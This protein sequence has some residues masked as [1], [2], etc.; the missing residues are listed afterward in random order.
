MVTP[1]TLFCAKV[2]TETTAVNAASTTVVRARVTS[3]AVVVKFDL[4]VFKL[5]S[6]AVAVA[7]KLVSSAVAVAA[8]L[9]SIA[10]TTAVKLAVA[11]VL[12]AFAVS[13][14]V[15]SVAVPVVCVAV[16]PVVSV[17]V[18]VEVWSVLP[19]VSVAPVVAPFFPR[20]L[21]PVEDVDRV[22]DV[23]EAAVTDFEA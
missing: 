11:V 23:V 6:T 22:D 10:V 16:V 1:D 20:A 14:A 19:V 3:S 9:V 21:C 4:A 17:E 15:D 5:A 8:N 2:A 13:D 7:V 18:E 12:L